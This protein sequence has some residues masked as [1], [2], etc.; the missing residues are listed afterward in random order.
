ML[1][2]QTVNS[3][4]TI[5]TRTARSLVSA[6]ALLLVAALSGCGTLDGLAG[7]G[8]AS[9]A[10]SIN[11]AQ[12]PRA[13]GSADPFLNSAG[14]GNSQNPIFF[15]GAG[16]TFNNPTNNPPANEPTDSS[17]GNANTGPGGNS[18]GGGG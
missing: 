12:A 11:F 1:N 10:G 15:P 9:P 8:Y 17:S 14:S 18:T 3:Q 2:H 13:P 6:A 7:F 4:R 5:T 16:N